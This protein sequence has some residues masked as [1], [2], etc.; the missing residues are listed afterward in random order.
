MKLG[1]R[2]SSLAAVLLLCL[3]LLAACKPRYQAQVQDPRATI[4]ADAPQVL[5]FD[6][7][8]N[9][10]VERYSDNEAYGFI[11]NMDISGSNDAPKTIRISMDCVEEVSDEALDIFMSLLLQ[12][13]SEEA[14]VQDSRYTGPTEDS[15]GSVYD[16]YDIQYR[17]SRGDTVYQDT[18]ISAGENIPFPAGVSL[19]G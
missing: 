17:I 6:Q 12:S 2:W 13:I 9:D 14:I 10:I 1:K 7:I 3:T 16:S 15:F 19:E 18:V 11:K 8:H 4:A 5:D